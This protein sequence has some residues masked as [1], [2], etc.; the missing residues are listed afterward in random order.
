MWKGICSDMVKTLFQDLSS[1]SQFDISLAINGLSHIVSPSLARD[2]SSDLITKMN[3]SNPYIRKKAILVMYK[4]F[5]Q[6]PELL[7]TAWPRLRE[8][9]NDD[10]PSVVNATV[11]VICELARKNPRNYLPLAPQ[12][13][14]LLTTSKTANNNWMTIKIIKLVRDLFF[15][16]LQVFA[17]MDG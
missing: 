3:H 9:L 12:L 7:R 15:F 8:G 5:L 2:L 1:A 16:I 13:F 10:D 6:S 14:G 17:N 4:C 11:N